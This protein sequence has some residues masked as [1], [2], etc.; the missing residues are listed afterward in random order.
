LIAAARHGRVLAFDNVS[1]IKADL[2]DSICRLATGAEIGGRALFTDHDIASF[3][4][5]RPIVVNGIPDLGAR[6]DLA[7]RSIIIKL[8]PLAE[9]VTER[10]FWRKVEAVL[11]SITA[12]LLD[13]MVAAAR[14]LDQ[15]PTPSV[16]MADFARLIRAAEPVLPDAYS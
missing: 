10:D 5:C 16:R 3:K 13:V 14:H 12:G 8:A 6:G 2:A 7:D 11:P 9:R 1:S 4:A 15:V